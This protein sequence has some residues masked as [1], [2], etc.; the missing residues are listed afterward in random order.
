M[1]SHL[2]LN[3]PG[4]SFDLYSHRIELDEVTKNVGQKYFS[5][6]VKLTSGITLGVKHIMEAKTVFVQLAGTQK[7][8]VVSRFMDSVITPEFPATVIKM[9]QNSFLLLDCEPAEFL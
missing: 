3:E 8:K 4:I 2:G 5:G 6:T 7:A 9:H 1:N